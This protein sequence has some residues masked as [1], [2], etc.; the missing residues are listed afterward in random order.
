MYLKHGEDNASKLSDKTLRKFV[1]SVGDNLE[2]VLDVIH[3]DNISHAGDTAMVNQINNVRERLKTLNMNVRKEN[4]K[5]PIDG[6]DL[7]QLGFKP[8]PIFR[9]ILD[10]VQD[11]WYENPNMTRDDALEIVKGI[12]LK[13][14]IN[15]IKTLIKKI[16]NE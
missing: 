6:N 4:M 1:A 11:D 12:K 2:Y 5:L 10:A 8:S 15:E 3:A 16:I 7:I 13:N 9:E 14:N